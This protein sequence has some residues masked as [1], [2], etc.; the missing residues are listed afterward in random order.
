MKILG[1]IVNMTKEEVKKKI[2][3]CVLEANTIIP[4][5]RGDGKTI[6]KNKWLGYYIAIYKV[7][8]ENKKGEEIVDHIG[9]EI[10]IIYDYEPLALHHEDK[11]ILRAKEDVDIDVDDVLKR[12]SIPLN[13]IKEIKLVDF[14]T[15]QQMIHNLTKLM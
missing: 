10:P 5:K 12:I 3:S 7:I 8:G 2:L 6:P 4:P 1:S 15:A 9:Y 11:E 13:E 14:K